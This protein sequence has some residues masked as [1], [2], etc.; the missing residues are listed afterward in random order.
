MRQ[1]AGPFPPLN[2]AMTGMILRDFDPRGSRKRPAH[3]LSVCD[4]ASCG[5]RRA[6]QEDGP[7]GSLWQSYQSFIIAVPMKL[8]G[9]LFIP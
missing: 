7:G 3:G 6:E 5:W 1:H 2:A 4:A 8:V 9:E